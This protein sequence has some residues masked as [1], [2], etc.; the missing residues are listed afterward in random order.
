[1]RSTVALGKLAAAKAQQKNVSHLKSLQE[2]ISQKAPSL[3]G[4]L[5]LDSIVAVREVFKLK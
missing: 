2:Y 3:P 5:S 1:M 4:G